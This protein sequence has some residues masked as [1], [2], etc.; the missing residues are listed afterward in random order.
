MNFLSSVGSAQARAARNGCA[1]KRY[2]GSWTSEYGDQYKCINYCEKKPGAKA[3]KVCGLTY[4]AHDTDH[5]WP[6]FVFQQAWKFFNQQVAQT[7]QH[8][9]GGASSA[10]RL[11]G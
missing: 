6:G 7:G 9:R 4:V 11:P 3:A 5:P 10:Y 2:W 1:D 8:G